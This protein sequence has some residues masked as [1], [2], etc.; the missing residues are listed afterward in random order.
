MLEVY[1]DACIHVDALLLILM[2]MLNFFN[3]I[4]I[5]CSTRKTKGYS[6]TNIIIIQGKSTSQYQVKHSWI[7]YTRAGMQP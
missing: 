7:S 1:I 2:L 5:F 4:W 6:R 3:L